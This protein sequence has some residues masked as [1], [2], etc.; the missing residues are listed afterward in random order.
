MESSSLLKTPTCLVDNFVGMRLD[1]EGM[2]QALEISEIKK[3][4][5]E[6]G[7]GQGHVNPSSI[8]TDPFERVKVGI[9]DFW[10]ALNVWKQQIFVGKYLDS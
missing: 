4:N 6:D 8:E 7:D 9:I 3:K 10:V 5:Q 2:E 1:Q